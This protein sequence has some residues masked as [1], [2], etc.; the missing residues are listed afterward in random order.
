ML[1]YLIDANAD[2]FLATQDGACGLHWASYCG[3]LDC[4][5]TLLD[6]SSI[7]KSAPSLRTTTASGFTPLMLAT[8]GGHEEVVRMMVSECG[9]DV[10]FRN[11]VGGH[12]FTRQWVMSTQLC[13]LGRRYR[14]ALCVLRG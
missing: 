3:R 1:K 14:L 13:C 2:I 5:R 8:C 9:A 12:S 10:N 4:V 11:E 6:V 7:R